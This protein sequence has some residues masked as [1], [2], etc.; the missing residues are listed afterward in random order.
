MAQQN[1]ARR[2]EQQ[3]F[4]PSADPRN[5]CESQARDDLRWNRRPQVGAQEFYTGN[6]RLSSEQS[7]KP[8]PYG[9][10][11]WQ[12]RHGLMRGGRVGVRQGGRMNSLGTGRSQERLY[13]PR[14]CRFTLKDVQMLSLVAV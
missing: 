7:L 13:R 6:D 11:F 2:I 1:A 12:F 3:V 8:S 14:P 10:N 4:G 9:F 5:G